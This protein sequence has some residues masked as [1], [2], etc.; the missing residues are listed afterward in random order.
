MLVATSSHCCARLLLRHQQRLLLHQQHLS[1]MK[2]SSAAL[3]SLFLLSRST[4]WTT[5]QHTFAARASRALLA[6][7]LHGSSSTTITET[8]STKVVGKEET[9]SFRLKFVEE[10]KAISPWHD[11]P[12]KN[13]DGSFNMVRMMFQYYILFV[14]LP[15]SSSI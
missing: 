13:D 7:Q 4:A 2:L 11:I 14:Y 9:E 1:T 3:S 8:V 10:K 15:L 12:L 6:T 5:N